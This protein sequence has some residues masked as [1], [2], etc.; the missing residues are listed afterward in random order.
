MV[1]RLNL[2]SAIS[3]ECSMSGS[4]ARQLESSSKNLAESST[5]IRKVGNGSRY[6]TVQYS[7]L[8]ANAHDYEE[9]TPYR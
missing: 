9:P 5:I 2:E 6:Y 8:A 7:G 1:T 3:I 4:I